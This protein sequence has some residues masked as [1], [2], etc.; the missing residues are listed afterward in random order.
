MKYMLSF[1]GL[2]NS[3]FFIRLMMHTR[4][5]KIFWGIKY[6]K[7]KAFIYNVSC[8]NFSVIY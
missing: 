8:F 6:E 1:K 3:M 5:Y 7:I 4:F 2:F